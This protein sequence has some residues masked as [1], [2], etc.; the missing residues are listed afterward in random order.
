MFFRLDPLQPLPGEAF[1]ATFDAENNRDGFFVLT[2]WEGT[3][4]SAP[5]FGLES[6]ANAIASVVALGGR[7]FGG[8]DYGVPGPG[9]DGLLL[10]ADMDPGRWRLCTANTAVQICTQFTVDP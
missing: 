1:T 2:R 5:Q 6:D 9:P 7:G 4:W 3:G 10:P 8:D